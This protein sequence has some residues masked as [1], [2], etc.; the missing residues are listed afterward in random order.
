[1]RKHRLFGV[2]IAV[3][4]G[5]GVFTHPSSTPHRSPGTDRAG[6]QLASAHLP[7]ESHQ[8][9]ALGAAMRSASTDALATPSASSAATEPSPTV[10]LDLTVNAAAMVSTPFGA[11][12]LINDD[13]LATQRRVA[14]HAYLTALSVEHA[15]E[16]SY[17]Q[18]VAV[19]R[20]AVKAY[21]AS[22]PRP[23]P[24]VTPRPATSD[25]WAALRRCESGGNYAEDTGNGYYGAYQFNL[26]TW[27]SL[28][29]GG[30]P[31][32]A[33]PAL[34]DQAARALQARRGWGQWPSCSRRLGL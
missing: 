32:Q 24:V 10:M 30:L 23:R 20:A 5:L 8:P 21:V 6:V 25:A 33:P 9:A 7:A 18:A 26:G 2:V 28:G 13:R 3:L 16:D 22:L 34:Q 11:E 19:E 14:E 15:E 12:A 17:L 4:L 1:M 31:S 27:K 29:Y